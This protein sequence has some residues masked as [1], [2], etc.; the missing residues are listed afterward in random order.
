[1]KFSPSLVGLLVLVFLLNL[2][3]IATLPIVNA[4]SLGTFAK[5]SDVRLIQTCNNCTYCNITSILYP[6][7]STIL[8]NLVMTQDKTVYSYNLTEGNTTVVG[9]YRYCYDCGNTAERTTGCIDFEITPNGRTVPSGAIVVLFSVFFIILV[10][11]SG[12]F[13]L[14]TLGHF[15]NLDFDIID[16]AVDFG[17]FFMIL[18]FYYLETYYLANP[19]IDN[20]HIVI[21]TF[22]GIL[23]LLVPSIALILSISIGALNPNQRMKIAVPRKI[24][25]GR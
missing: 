11:L 24:R 17:I 7:S 16:L 4:V 22:S 20:M 12:Y 2:V 3:F 13:I 5:D 23:F 8:S 25:W 10:G 6:N 9:T 14:Y 15:V 18:A 21:L 19:F 1:M